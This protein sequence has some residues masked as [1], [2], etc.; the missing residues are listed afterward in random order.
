LRMG[1][2]PW[3]M[4]RNSRVTNVPI[5]PRTCEPLAKPLALFSRAVCW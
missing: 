1:I 5:N 3:K 2:A 4:H